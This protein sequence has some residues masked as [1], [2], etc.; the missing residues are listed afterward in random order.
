MQLSANKSA[1][2]LGDD[3]RVQAPAARWEAR[4]E[5]QAPGSCLAQP[6]FLWPFGKWTREWNMDWLITLL[7]SPHIA[8]P[9]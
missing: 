5:F 2:A 6:Q 9:S 1:K 4:V 7:L 8:L 3:P